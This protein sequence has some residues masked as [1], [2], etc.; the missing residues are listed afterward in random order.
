VYHW[1]EVGLQDVLRETG[2]VDLGSAIGHYQAALALDLNE[3]TANRRLAQIE[4]ARGQID[5]ACDHL[6]RANAD[7]EQRATRQL[8][9]E[10]YALRG[11]VDR[12]VEVW[13]TIDLSEG[14]LYGRDWWY[15]AHL[16]SPDQAQALRRAADALGLP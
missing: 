6:E 16:A 9:G 2:G 8:L 5:A 10:C 3:V 12:A 1:P 7:A 13:R 15:G 4:L 11:E 14:Q